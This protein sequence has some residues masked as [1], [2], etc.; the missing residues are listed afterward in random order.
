MTI[1]QTQAKGI[2]RQPLAAAN[3]LNGTVMYQNNFKQH[4][5]VDLEVFLVPRV[6]NSTVAMSIAVTFAVGIVLV[7]FTPQEDLTK[8]RLRHVWD[9]NQFPSD[10]L[11]PKV[12]AQ[13]LDKQRTLGSV[14]ICS[15]VSTRLRQRALLEGPFSRGYL[16]ISMMTRLSVITLTVPV[17]PPPSVNGC[18]NPECS[19]RETSRSSTSERVSPLVCK[20]SVIGRM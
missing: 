5:L 1:S 15:A 13:S 14:L 16:P 3:L 4:F 10:D 12:F 11:L 7:V 6:H 8:D 20:D 2:F 9:G 19:V 18:L 17:S